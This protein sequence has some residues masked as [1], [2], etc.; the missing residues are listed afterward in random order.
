ML[1][2]NSTN[3]KLFQNYNLKDLF[4]FVKLKTYKLNQHK[5]R[6][7]ALTKKKNNRFKEI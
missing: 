6:P 1:F 2:F 4:K 5:L 3:I 7:P